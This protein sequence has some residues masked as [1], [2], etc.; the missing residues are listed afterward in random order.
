ML[1]RGKPL[2]DQIRAAHYCARTILQ[3][4]GVSLPK[5]KPDVASVP[6]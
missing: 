4:S 1:A 3:V 5:H 2:D 6:L